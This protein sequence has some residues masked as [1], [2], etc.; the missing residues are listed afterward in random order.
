MDVLTNVVRPYAWGS[1]TAIAELLGQPSPSPEP[2]AELW[3]GAHPSAPS[4]VIRQGRELGLDACILEDPE[5]ALGPA[6]LAAFGP[7]LPFLLKVLAAGAPL[8]LQAHPSLAQARE[9]F[10]LE[11]A[12]GIPLDAPTRNYRDRN[13]KPELICALTPFWA[14]CGFRDVKATLSLFHALAAPSLSPLAA[15]LEGAKDPSPGL[16]ATLEAL[17]EHQDK[18]GLVADTLEGA[19]RLVR[20]GGPFE[21][22]ASWALRLGQAYPGDVGVVVALLLNL[23]RLAPGE[24][25]F[26]GAG[27]LHAYLEG[28]GIELMA[29]SDN[30]LRGGLT[31]KHVDVPGLLSLLDFRAGPASLAPRLALPSGEILYA[32]PA[33]EFLLSRLRLSGKASVSPSKGPEIV[34]CTGGGAE[35][36]QGASSGRVTRGQALFLPASGSPIELRGDATLYRA[37]VSLGR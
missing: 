3:M 13:H 4:R 28:T 1:R 2:Q 14:L 11:E 25:L 30:V 18:E 34:L 8:S 22:E 32:T 35:L 15:L 29:S 10:D 24:A 20:A 36:S 21:G 7:T 37:R 31:V 27:N 9:G 33:R 12:R 6:S 17:F 5:R 26:L 23:V 16:R 19:G